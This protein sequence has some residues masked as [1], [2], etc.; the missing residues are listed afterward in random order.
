MNLADAKEGVRVEFQGKTRI[1]VIDNKKNLP[2]IRNG[3]AKKKQ[4]W[5]W[6]YS[7]WN[8]VGGEKSKNKSSKPTIHLI[9][10]KLIHIC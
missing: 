3:I 6:D 4:K 7:K 10:K 5:S 2:K 9:W 8:L 1:V